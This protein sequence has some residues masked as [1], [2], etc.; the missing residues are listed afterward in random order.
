MVGLLLPQGT[1][2]GDYANNTQQ[3]KGMLPLGKFSRGTGL[4]LNQRHEMV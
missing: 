4:A 3:F 1:L 2:Y